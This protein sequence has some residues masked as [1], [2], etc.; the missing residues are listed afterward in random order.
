MIAPHLSVFFKIMHYVYILKSKK[1][2]SLYIGFTA[3]L[4]KRLVQHN[5]GQSKYTRSFS[6]WV[7]VYYE[8][9][10][11]KKDAFER[12]R[13]LKRHKKAWGQLKRRIA[14]SINEN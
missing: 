1:N 13:Q 3:D 12:E 5:K 14:N 6:P 9:Y 10:S 2:G 11:S 7:L 8:S 4:R